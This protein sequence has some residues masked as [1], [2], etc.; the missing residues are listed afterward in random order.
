MALGSFLTPVQCLGTAANW[1]GEL[2][3]LVWTSPRGGGVTQR[4]LGRE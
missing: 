4:W 3:I 1:C 2:Y